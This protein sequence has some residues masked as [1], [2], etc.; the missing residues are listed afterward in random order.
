TGLSLLRGL[1]PTQQAVAR[2]QVRLA[3]SEVEG[4]RRELRKAFA[5][6]NDDQVRRKLTQFRESMTQLEDQ[7][8]LRFERTVQ[9]LS[10]AVAQGLHEPVWKEVLARDADVDGNQREPLVA[11]ALTPLVAFAYEDQGGAAEATKIRTEYANRWAEAGPAEELRVMPRV[12]KQLAKQGDMA[13]LL[14]ALNPAVSESGQL[15]ET[16]LELASDLVNEGR[17]AEA[18]QLASG[19]GLESL[20]EDALYLVAARSARLDKGA[21]VRGALAGQMKVTDVSAIQS[22]LAAGWG[23]LLRTQK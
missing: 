8:N 19:L 13:G 2:L 18:L 3:D 14:A 4:L 10:G 6:A 23:E 11:T 12:L 22:G 7:A 5:L 15:Q 1:G 17:V 9:L 16:A 20:R 21:A